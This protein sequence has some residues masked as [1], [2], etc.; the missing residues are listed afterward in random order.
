MTS[1]TT[2]I[3]PTDVVALAAAVQAGQPIPTQAVQAAALETHTWT[4]DS[5]CPMRSH[6]RK[7]GSLVSLYDLEHPESVITPPASVGPMVWLARCET[8]ASDFY[9]RT[10]SPA[11]K[12]RNRPWEFCPECAAIFASRYGKGLSKPR[13]AGRKTKTITVAPP[14]IKAVA[15]TVAPIEAVPPGP[16]DEPDPVEE[17]AWNDWSARLVQLTPAGTAIE[18]VEEYHYEIVLPDQRVI[19]LRVHKGDGIFR[20]RDDQGKAHY[21]D[22]LPAL[23]AEIG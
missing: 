16:T 19:E 8:H 5:A 13:K 3:D 15:K 6:N 23:L 11:W 22:D 21:A 2:Q 10:I 20:Y 7:V 1:E 14:T 18:W 9:S 17:A 12:A 4:P